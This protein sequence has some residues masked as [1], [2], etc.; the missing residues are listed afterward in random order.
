[1][2]LSEEHFK[3]LKKWQ[4]FT[5]KQIIVDTTFSILGRLSNDYVETVKKQ[6]PDSDILI[7]SHPW[8]YP[9]VRHEIDYD[10]KLVIYDSHNV[11]G[12]LRFELLDDGGFGSDI[13][14]TVV[15]NE[16]ELSHRADAILVCSGL[17]KE[18]FKSFYNLNPNKMIEIPNGV[19]VES[20][21]PPNEEQK[22]YAKEKCNINRTAAI[23]LGSDYLPNVE[24]AEFI[25]KDIAPKICEVQFII[26]G[27]VSES[28]RIKIFDKIG[29]KN[30]ILTGYVTHD[31]KRN[32]L[33]ASDLALNPMSK[34]SGTNIKM[35][36]FMAAGLPV[37]STSAGA[38]GIDCGD[39]EA[40]K[41]TTLGDFK[42][43]IQELIEFP[44]IFKE[45]SRNSR[46]IVEENYAYEK[47]SRDL[48]NKLKTL[49]AEK[50]SSRDCRI[51][52]HFYKKEELRSTETSFDT[53]DRVEI[54]AN[55]ELKISMMTTWDVKCGIA[56]YSSYLVNAWNKQG[57]YC[58]ILAN[59]GDNSKI[60]R[61]KG[62]I[63]SYTHVENVWNH[64]QIGDL[65][66][67]HII[68][69][70]SGIK[71]FCIQYHPSFFSEKK[72]VGLSATCIA[73]SINILITLHNIIEMEKS[74][75]KA[76]DEIGANVLIHRESDVDR[77]SYEGIQNVA[78]MPMGVIDIEFDDGLANSR[79][80]NHTQGPVISTFGFLRPHK[81]LAELISAV[82][83]LKE[84]YPNIFLNAFCSL[85]PSDDSHE[86]LINCQK[87][88]NTSNLDNHTEINSD[89]MDIKSVIK[90]LHQSDL[91]VLPYKTTNEG[92]SA[93][94]STAIAAKRPV[95]TT[96][97][98]IFEDLR[99][100]T[101]QVENNHYSS[102][103]LGIANVLS[104]PFLM[105]S[106]RLKSI[107]YAEKNSWQNVARKYLVEICS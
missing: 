19:F 89:F 72:L 54:K 50:I 95:I 26:C 99:K 43:A 105:E 100:V 1:V 102:L 52:K 98:E 35:F 7:F 91:V 66:V 8:V 20:L 36:D 75:I 25:C 55:N 83:I 90:K 71:N 74:T 45:M 21:F 96:K 2:P 9:L 53:I 77:L 56:E 27:S 33:W 32:W 11:E 69:H 87:A 13:A 47:I 61:K 92:A 106:L 79:N 28:S 18:G 34:G 62:L 23:F 49:Y 6:L 41:I 4:A 10:E 101:Y 60:S 46:Q 12:L 85:Y 59:K 51:A 37:I 67:N 5:D 38:R 94:A 63:N 107:E 65:D 15:C 3:V 78:Y 82:D 104:S 103:A 97:L 68:R 24:A 29:P 40:I 14:A 84:L 44:K 30:I 16:Y 76:L 88:I 48:G 70:L 86:C 93:S 81:G 57:I 58:N 73:N 42:R 31:D 22:K 39:L 17:D 80:F 64:W